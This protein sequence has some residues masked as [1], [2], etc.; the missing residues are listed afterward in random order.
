MHFFVKFI[1]FFLMKKNIFFNKKFL[2]EIGRQRKIRYSIRG[3][4][5]N[6]FHLFLSS[7]LFIRLRNRVANG[8]W[9]ETCILYLAHRVS[10]CG[11]GK[12]SSSA[13][14]RQNGL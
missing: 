8:T 3:D 1:Y 10:L 14:E 2:H 7:E 9:L 6:K 11:S 5:L 12:R 4:K 13:L